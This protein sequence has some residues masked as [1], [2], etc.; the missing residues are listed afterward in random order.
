M[1]GLAPGRNGANRTGRVFT[2]DYAGDLLFST[3]L[4][5]GFAAGHYAADPDDGLR[6]CDT[7]ISNA[8]RCA[9][10]ANKPTLSEIR[11]CGRFLRRRIATL[12]EL[13]VIVTLGG[14]AHEACLR[15]LDLRPRAAPFA[16]G[17]VADLISG[18]RHLRMVSSYHCSRYNTNTGVLTAAMFES[19]FSGVRQFLDDGGTASAP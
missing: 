9:P 13:R 8:V 18:A 14:I 3:L 6:L 11:T 19:V 1:L 7:M 17:A 4:K 5:Y 2:G 15:A 12:P 10:P 16:H